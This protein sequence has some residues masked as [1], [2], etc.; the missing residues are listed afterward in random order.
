M[1]KTLNDIKKATEIMTCGEH[2]KRAEIL[3]KGTEI[4]FSTCCDNFKN[5]LLEVAKKATSDSVLEQMK[6]AFK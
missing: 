6:D 2:S 4:T 1:T 5:E 3:L